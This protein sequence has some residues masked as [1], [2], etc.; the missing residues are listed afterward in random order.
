[1]ELAVSL[2]TAADEGLQAILPAAKVA[3]EKD[4]PLDMLAVLNQLQQ[5]QSRLLAAQVALAQAQTVRQQINVDLLSARPRILLTEQVDPLLQAVQGKFRMEDALLLVKAAPSMLGVG[6]AGPKT[7]LLLIQ[8]EDELRPTGGFI[9]AVGSV[10]I[11]DSQVWDL[12]SEAVEMVDDFEKPYPQAPWQ[13]DELMGL[14]ILTL[15]D[16]NWSTDF[17]TAAALAEYFYSYTRAHTVDGVIAIDQHV[18]IELLKIL[19]PVHVEGTL[20]A[21]T[22]ENVQQYM[23]TSKEHAPP[24]TIGL[25]DRKQFIGRLAQP[26]LEKLLGARGGELSALSQTLV[27]LLDQRHILLQFDDPDLTAFLARRRWDGAVRAPVKSDFLMVVDTNMSYNKSNAVLKTA[28]TYEVDLSSLAQPVSRLTVQHTNHATSTIPCILYLPRSEATRDYPIDECHWTYL[29]VYTPA[30]T[31]LLGASP[32]AIPAE[33]TM[34]GIAIPPRVDDLGNED[35]P[36]I[37]A[38]GTLVVIPQRQTVQTGFEFGLPGAVLQTEAKGI[39]TYR[40]TIQK[41][42]GIQTVPLTLRLSLPA[43]AK[44]LSGPQDLLP[45]DGF[46]SYTTTLTEDAVL[47]IT[48]SVED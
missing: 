33:Q 10:V 37:Q 42:P 28:L 17:P 12:H 13:L 16:S 39:W 29:R 41:Q 9:T 31:K 7:Y 27:D 6:K 48:F 15:R 26:L 32:H 8:N 40:L 30:G 14:P 4:Q 47:E 5:N 43:A 24:G 44:L 21:I 35:L 11:R 20:T 46:W 19:G 45:G 2:S 25:W 34:A 38:F 22:G 18:V 1:V 3:L 36:G 23:R